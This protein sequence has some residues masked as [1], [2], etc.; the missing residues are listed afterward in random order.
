MDAIEFRT[1][2]LRKCCESMK[3]AQRRWGREAAL[4]L[5]QRLQELRAADNV[6]ELML[7][8][9]A[10]CHQLKGDRAGQFAVD[11]KHPL[12]LV[13]RALGDPGEY[14]EGP[15][16]KLDMVTQIEILEVTDYHG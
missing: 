4:K 12:R 6:E 7:L 10:R 1:R 9:A 3:E 16:I 15:Q 11:L 13:F 8:P 5:F 2:K 14:M